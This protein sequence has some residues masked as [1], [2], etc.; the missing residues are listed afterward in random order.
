MYNEPF[1]KGGE[2]MNGIQILKTVVNKVSD[3]D[4]EGL[5]AALVVIV[6][7]ICAIV[8]ILCSVK[9][10]EN[11]SS[12]FIRVVSVIIA[13]SSFIWGTFIGSK[14][15]AFV[16]KCAYIGEEYVYTVAI[17]EDVTFNEL[18]DQFGSD[19]EIQCNGDG[20][21]IISKTVLAADKD[22]K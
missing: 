18:I 2:V 17:S 7:L 16:T 9:V 3:P 19:C 12:K 13:A 5:A 11:T 22:N 21:Y 20:T 14:T 10:F 1:P 15:G 8:S 4:I 6:T